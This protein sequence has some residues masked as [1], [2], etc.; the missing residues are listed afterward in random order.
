MCGRYTL[1]VTV[2]DLQELL[3][4]F[5]VQGTLSPRYNVAPTQVMPIALVGNDAG[6]TRLVSPARWGLIPRWA[7]DRAIG[8]RLI[9]AR[10]ETLA[11]KPSFRDAFKKRRCLVPATGFYEWRKD[12]AREGAKGPARKTPFLI[13]APGGRPFTFAGLWEDWMS[14]EGV[15][16]SFTIITTAPSEAVASVHDR[17]PVILPAEA[18]E[19]WVATAPREAPDLRRLLVPYAGELELIEVSTRVNSPANDSPECL[20]P[21]A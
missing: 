8:S 5:E 4:D 13:R 14:P 1:S 15:T 11:E 7:K 2:S 12:E 19:T 3:P 18:R 16:R 20:A 10:S 21:R 17:M 9:N 6:A